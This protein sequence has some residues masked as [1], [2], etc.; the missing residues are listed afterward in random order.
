MP[1]SPQ[2]AAVE[3]AEPACRSDLLSVFFQPLQPCQPS[4]LSAS[5]PLAPPSLAMTS[6]TI[7]YLI[8]PEHQLHTCPHAPTCSTFSYL[9]CSPPSICSATIFSFIP[10]SAAT[11]S[12]PH[13]FL[14]PPWVHHSTPMHPI[15][16]SF[17]TSGSL[18]VP[19]S[20]VSL[21]LSVS[22]LLSPPH[23]LSP[24]VDSSLL[25]SHH[26]HPPHQHPA[27]SHI[28]FISNSLASYPQH[29]SPYHSDPSLT[30][31]PTTSSS[32]F[33]LPPWGPRSLSSETSKFF[34]QKPSAIILTWTASLLLSNTVNP[35]WPSVHP[36]L[37]PPLVGTVWELLRNHR[38]PLPPSRPLLPMFRMAPDLP[39]RMRTRSGPAGWPSRVPYYHPSSSRALWLTTVRTGSPH[40]A[41]PPPWPPPYLWVQ[42]E[43]EVVPDC[44][45]SFATVPG[46][47][48]QKPLCPMSSDD[49]S[50]L[51]RNRT[52]PPTPDQCAELGRAPGWG[53]PT[54]VSHSKHPAQAPNNSLNSQHLL[55]A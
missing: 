38:P 5:H 31:I 53:Q 41:L 37:S 39:Q 12:S 6:S 17:V 19:I 15:R 45:L 50:N 26:P 25:C 8:P 29:F 35:S 36:D 28:P 16:S 32:A 11:P 54:S 23:H 7:I 48:P 13:S 42:G 55:R 44:F 33:S 21:V 47:G 27:L 4:H 52:P 46:I 18:T 24:M 43:D 9:S 34:S 49:F 14:C 40:P 10:L 20:S 3:V 30:L 22:P 51:V 1:W 2:E